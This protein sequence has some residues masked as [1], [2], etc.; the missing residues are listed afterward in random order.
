MQA[1]YVQRKHRGSTMVRA[2]ASAAV[3]LAT[4]CHSEELAPKNPQRHKAQK[5]DMHKES[6]EDFENKF[7]TIHGE[8]DFGSSGRK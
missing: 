7:P 8:G 6:N 4:A 3:K 2:A 5:I 1:R